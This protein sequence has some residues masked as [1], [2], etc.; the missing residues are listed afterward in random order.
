MYARGAKAGSIFVPD[1]PA[2]LITSRIG[3]SMSVCDLVQ[4]NAPAMQRRGG[5]I[6]GYMDD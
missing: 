3:K 2:F 1:A 6:G 5:G 4:T